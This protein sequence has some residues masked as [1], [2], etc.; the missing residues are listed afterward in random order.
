[1]KAVKPWALQDAKARLSEVVKKAENDGPQFISVR[2]NPVVV[3]I[4]QEEY[5]LLI[6]PQTSVFDSLRKSPLVGL[7]L[8]FDR[9]K[10]LPRDID[11]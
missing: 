9:D 5:L 6:A 2:G 11:L 10:S 8:K 4:S 1:M 7:H 3:V